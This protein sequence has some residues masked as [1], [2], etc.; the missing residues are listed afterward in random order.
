MLKADCWFEEVKCIQ[1]WNVWQKILKISLLWLREILEKVW[2]RIPPF[3]LSQSLQKTFILIC[4]P[5]ETIR[6]FILKHLHNKHYWKCLS[7]TAN[8]SKHYEYQF[9]YKNLYWCD[10]PILLLLQVS[11][12]LLT[13]V[14][15]EVIE[16][17]SK[18]LKLLQE[19][20]LPDSIK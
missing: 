16:N 1:N 6:K 11:W 13:S 20:K 7:P 2:E 4:I 3:P 19:K 8:L 14:Y 5:L 18:M 17:K 12:Y 9:I 10:R 15:Q